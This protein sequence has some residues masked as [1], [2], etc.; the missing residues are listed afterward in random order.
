MKTNLFF[1]TIKKV[2]NAVET[3]YVKGHD[4]AEI[5]AKIDVYIQSISI[6][7]VELPSIQEIKLIGKILI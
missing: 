5:V 6:I 1:V 3:I 2:N 7:G 4:I